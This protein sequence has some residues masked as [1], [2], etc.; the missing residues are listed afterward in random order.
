MEN[1][2]TGF[3]N[4]DFK[5]FDSYTSDFLQKE[6]YLDIGGVPVSLGLVAENSDAI[7]TDA[8]PGD[9]ERADE[10][11][12]TI[13]NLNSALGNGKI[14]FDFLDDA[15]RNAVLN[16]GI[17]KSNEVANKNVKNLEASIEQIN[18]LIKEVLKPE[19]AGI[20]E[21]QDFSSKFS[22]IKGTFFEQIY[23]PLICP[24]KFLLQSGNHGIYGDTGALSDTQIS[25]QLS[26][27]F[28]LNGCPK[29]EE[30]IRF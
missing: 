28:K 24:I 14:R 8:Y 23:K 18:S 13:N 26:D 19:Y 20:S 11:K 30:C 6:R 15:G 21:D 7:T 17:N 4:F 9:T 3:V 2:N 12:T 10:R 25:S 5:A 29:H 1:E 27:I 16:N 22:E